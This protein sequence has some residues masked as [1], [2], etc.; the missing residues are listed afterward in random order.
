[1]SVAVSVAYSF[2]YPAVETPLSHT[3]E[4]LNGDNYLPKGIQTNEKSTQIVVWN[5]NGK[6]VH[7]TQTDEN[8]L[9]FMAILGKDSLKWWAFG[10]DRTDR[11]M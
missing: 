8:G 10:V 7:Y 2:A 11:G 3:F 1:M 4:I 5:L 6:E 9:F